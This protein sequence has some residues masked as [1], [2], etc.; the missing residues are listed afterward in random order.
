[1]PLCIGY[2]RYMSVTLSC[3]GYIRYMSVTPSCVGYISYTQY[4]AC[5]PPLN[6][7]YVSM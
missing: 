5:S 2:I 4:M 1:M 7:D 6:M 3:I